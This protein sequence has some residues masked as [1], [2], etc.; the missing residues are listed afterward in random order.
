VPK[1]TLIM[2]DAPDAGDHNIHAP[3]HQQPLL[4]QLAQQQAQMVQQQQ[5]LHAAQQAHQAAQQAAQ[6]AQQAM[7][8][9]QQQVAMQQQVALQQQGAAQLAGGAPGGACYRPAVRV[10]APDKYRG[11]GV[12]D[13][14]IREMEVVF[15]YHRLSEA[16]KLSLTRANL[17][18]AALLWY[19]SIDAAHKANWTTVVAALRARYRPMVASLSA[20]DQLTRLRWNERQGVSGYI[21]QFRTTMALVNGMDRESQVVAFL[22]GLPPSLRARVFEQAQKV[23]DDVEAAM[24]AAITA[25]TA[26]N[27][28]RSGFLGRANN[29]QQQPNRSYGAGA[30]SGPTA[31][32]LSQVAT[33]EYGRDEYGSQQEESS[34]A[35][36][37]ASSSAEVKQLAATVGQL[38]STVAAL[39]QSSGGGWKSSTNK[40]GHKGGGGKGG[41]RE[42][43]DRRWVEGLTS[44][45]IRER[46][47][48]GACFV[49]GE[50]GHMKGE[51]PK[52]QP[53][54]Q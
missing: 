32:D 21:D 9:L 39:Q 29:Y 45:Q 24:Q 31:M 18:G 27:M 1:S 49:C 48:R 10:Y 36:A 22:N 16:E 8:A 14:W 3:A 11:V 12:V 44:E 46:S 25:E 52:Y 19:E 28:G 34:G 50:Q 43:R 40:G 35:A 6:A 2:Q 30:S 13:N 15:D 26:A 4:A 42:G 53:G 7:A 5:Q 38:A 41:S 23:P 37:A 47:A 17:A 51:C 20:R 33:G 54:K